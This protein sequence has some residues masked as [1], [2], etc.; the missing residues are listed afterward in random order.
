MA[1]IKIRWLA[2]L[3]DGS[4]AIEGEPPFHSV[5]GELSPWGK[6]LK[7]IEESGH[8]ITGMR[9][10]IERD[11]LPTMTINLPSLRTDGRSGRHERYTH[12]TPRLPIRFEQGRRIEGTVGGAVDWSHLFIAAVYEDYEVIIF[13][14]EKDGNEAWIV[15]NERV[16]LDA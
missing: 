2:S 14:D 3:S 9:V 1:Q 12:I 13:V 5:R 15:V 8:K 10:Q 6:L 4:T 7:H 11:G 16:G